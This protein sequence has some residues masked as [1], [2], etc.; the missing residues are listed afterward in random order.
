MLYITII[1]SYATVQWNTR[2][3]SYLWLGNYW[4]TSHHL[5]IPHPHPPSCLVATIYYLVLWVQLFKHS[6]WVRSCGAW[7]SMPDFFQLT[8]SSSTH[9]VTNDKVLTF[10]NVWNVFHHVHTCHFICLPDVGHLGCLH[11]LPIAKSPA[12]NS[13]IKM[14]LWRSV[15]HN[16]CSNLHSHQ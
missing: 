4:S 15:F 5:F 13:G 10:F 6:I 1:C 7:L 9:V 2:T 14:S 12:K 16:D 11:S 8:M 3:F